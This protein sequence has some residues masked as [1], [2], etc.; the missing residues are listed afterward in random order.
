[1]VLN[2]CFLCGTSFAVVVVVAV[3]QLLCTYPARRLSDLP[4]RSA[5]CGP[6]GAPRPHLSSCYYTLYVPVTSNM[7]G[8][9]R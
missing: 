8:P 5:V 6:A 7:S 4:L 2:T 1:M 9:P 3:E